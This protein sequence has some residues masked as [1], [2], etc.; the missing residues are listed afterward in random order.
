MAS[1][2]GEKKQR[3]FQREPVTFR[4]SAAL[5]ERFDQ[6]VKARGIKRSYMVQQAVYEYIQRHERELNNQ[7]RQRT[8]GS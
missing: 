3:G 6:L 7:R 5:L 4:I 8:F 1:A 2:A